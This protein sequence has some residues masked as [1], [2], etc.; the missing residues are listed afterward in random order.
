MAAAGSRRE[1]TM[2][3][4]MRDYLEKREKSLEARVERLSAEKM[5]LAAALRQ[6]VWAMEDRDLFGDDP[7]IA[8]AIDRAN[9]A[10]RKTEPAPE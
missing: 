9:D 4:P 10:L 6:A 1:A 8:K 5:L 2:T 7:R 3:D